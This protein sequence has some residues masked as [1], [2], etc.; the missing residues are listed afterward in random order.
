MSTSTPE[1]RAEAAARTR[2]WYKANRARALATRKAYY[3]THKVE[4]TAK[5]KARRAGDKDKILVQKAAYRLR[6]RDHILDKALQARHGINTAERDRLLVFQDRK[7]GCCRSP[8]TPKQSKVDHDHAKGSGREAVRGILCEA[9]NTILGRMGD[10]LE[11]VLRFG[12]DMGWQY[13]RY[14][15]P[16]TQAC[17][18]NW[19]S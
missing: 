2:A 9:C 14:M 10:T 7:C 12:W 5:A 19:R 11:G 17:L 16:L 6:R 18:R 4:I 1:Q 15:P 3:S 13:L 8:L